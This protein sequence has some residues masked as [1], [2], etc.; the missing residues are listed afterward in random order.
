MG[1][2]ED[3]VMDKGRGQGDGGDGVKGICKRG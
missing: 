3:R 2:L 1:K